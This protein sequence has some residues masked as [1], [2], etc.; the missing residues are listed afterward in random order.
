MDTN[1]EVDMYLASTDDSLESLK[2]FP[3]I[4]RIYYNYNTILV[5]SSSVERVFSYGKLVYETK[6][7]SLSDFNFEK[8]LLLNCNKS[9]IS[10]MKK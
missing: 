9:F 7:H 1:S 10:D 2:N 4:C 5:A 6:R 8:Q 3:T